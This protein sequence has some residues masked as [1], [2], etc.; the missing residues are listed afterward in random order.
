[1]L[2]GGSGVAR[3]EIGGHIGKAT[4]WSVVVRGISHRPVRAHDDVMAVEPWGLR[5]AEVPGILH[6][7]PYS[8]DQHAKLSRLSSGKLHPSVMRD[9]IL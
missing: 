3:L 4:G 5:A 9:P 2:L 8:H 6:T 7:R 1:M